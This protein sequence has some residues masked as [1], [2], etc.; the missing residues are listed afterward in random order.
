[1]AEL[2]IVIA[3][4]NRAEFVIRDLVGAVKEELVASPSGLHRLRVKWRALG[5]AVSG[6]DIHAADHS[7]KET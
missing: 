3:A 7:E 5:F 6:A 1:M 2:E 4:K